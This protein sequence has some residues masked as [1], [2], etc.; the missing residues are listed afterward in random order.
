MAK[1]KKTKII[2]TL[3]C[4]AVIAL[5]S[6]LPGM[7]AF[8]HLLRDVPRM[9]GLSDIFLLVSLDDGSVIFSQNE[10]RRTAP[11][12]LTKVVTTILV[13]EHVEDLQEVVTAQSCCVN[14]FAGRQAAL[15]HIRVGEELT[16]ETL[17]YAMMLH[18]ANDA[19][20]MLAHHVGGDCGPTF[21]AMMNAFVQRLGLEN[22]RFANAH[23]LDESNHYTTAADMA[24]ISRYAYGREFSG[25]AIFERMAGSLRFTMPETNLRNP[26]H[27]VNTNRMINRYF[28]QYFL[29][30]VM[31]GK[32][33]FTGD[34]GRCI[35]ATASRAG[36]RFLVIV[37]GGQDAAV[38]DGPVR[39]TA[40]LDARALL[41]WAFA[42]ITMQ[43]VTETDRAVAE[44]PVAMARHTD[45]VQLVPA[46]Q[47]FAFVPD[48]VHAGNVL[49]VPIAEDMPEELVAPVV[50][51]QHV[52]RARIMFAGAEFAQVDLVAAEDV[53]RSATLYFVELARRAVQTTIAR[54]L[55]V[56]V[57]GVA[58]LYLVLV[59]IQRSK[60]K[61]ERQMSVV[62]G[63]TTRYNDK[64]G[65]RR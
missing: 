43:Q 47:L 62:P 59:L 16:V 2:L 29:S 65:K 6:V 1:S 28:P 32:T 39:N 64:S 24:V 48:G 41:E 17:L 20:Q 58:A 22:T 40:K 15:A 33:G 8:N 23:G 61:N 27:L 55:L 38:N 42:N 60:K 9:T 10:N 44:I 7:A 31:G 25:S 45:H 53:D 3:C 46:E 34:A 63:V 12:S 13:L 19:A 18:S 56:I 5:A 49:L 52:G 54:V 35:M 51:G 37:M 26:Q 50:A 36:F 11:A 30:D 4:A 14:A 57:L 21:V